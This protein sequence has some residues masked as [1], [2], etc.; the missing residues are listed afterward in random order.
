MHAQKTG[1]ESGP[2]LFNKPPMHILTSD[3]VNY[4]VF[5]Y[6]QEAGFGHSA[7]TF[8][9]EA[10]VSRMMMDPNN[11][12]PGTLVALIQ[13]GMQ[14]LELEVNIDGQ[15]GEIDGE[16]KML[17]PEELLTAD[18]DQL[19]QLVQERREDDRPGEESWQCGPGCVAY[20]QI[21]Q[22]GH[23][24]LL[25]ADVVGTAGQAGRQGLGHRVRRGVGE[26]CG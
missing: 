19:R 5:R 2:Q 10:Q 1:C 18:I 8:A 12:A 21:Y 16:L 15:D 3:H 20:H 26:G 9:H 14:Y 23:T 24:S 22:R 7:F 4:M 6:L 25:C 17:T 11:V 13:K